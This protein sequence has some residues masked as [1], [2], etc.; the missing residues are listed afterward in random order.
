MTTTK[1]APKT[2]SAAA[3]SASKETHGLE[4]LGIPSKLESLKKS[5]TELLRYIRSEFLSLENSLFRC[6]CIVEYVENHQIYEEFGYS[7]TRQFLVN[8]LKID[9]SYASRIRLSW[10]FLQAIRE[11]MPSA[12]PTESQVRE[13]RLGVIRLGLPPEDGPRFAARRLK[14]LSK[15]GRRA[16]TAAEI[17]RSFEMEIIGPAKAKK[18]VVSPATQYELA[19]VLSWVGECSSANE[20]IRNMALSLIARLELDSHLFGDEYVIELEPIPLRKIDL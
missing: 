8:E 1:T 15:N 11:I 17:H 7:S 9:A 3:A 6:A 10:P 4:H 18:R 16:V 14:K 13:L 2:I 12:R 20:S 5:R 19:Q